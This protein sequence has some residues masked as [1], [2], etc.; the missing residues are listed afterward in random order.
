MNA[1]NVRRLLPAL[2]LY[3]FIH[4]RHMSKVEFDAF[5]TRAQ[6]EAANPSFKAYFPLCVP[7]TPGSVTP[8][9]TSAG[10]CASDESPDRISRARRK[11][12]RLDCGFGACVKSWL[13]NV[14]TTE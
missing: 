3:P 9:T 7:I 5:I 4:R 8:L 11:R 13:N 6:D 12:L 14:A 1:E 10:T 2:A